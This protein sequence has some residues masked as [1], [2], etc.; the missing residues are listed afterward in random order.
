MSPELIVLL[1]IGAFVLLIL[2]EVP[3]GI[4]IG[5]AGVF[6]LVLL[7]GTRIGGRVLATTP[8]TASAKYALIVIPMYILLGT[9][10][11][12]AG[13]G[14]RIYR[15]VNRGVRRLP[16][17]LGAAAV[18]A[19]ALFSGISGSSAADVATFGRISVNEMTRHGYS[20]EYAAAVVAAAGTF[21]ALIPPSVTLVIYAIV[22]GENVGAM[23][24]AGVVPGALS[25]IIL[26]GMVVGRATIGPPSVGG[27]SSAALTNS[28][29]DSLE[30]A[31]SG[32]TAGSGTSTGG[33]ALAERKQ[34]NRA[35][36]VAVLYAAI[37]FGIVVGGLYGGVFTPTESGAVGALAAL[38][39]AL[40]A[41]RSSEMSV[42]QLLLRSLR[43][44]ASVTAMIFLL[45]IG[46]AIFSILIASSRIPADLT[47]WASSLPVPPLLI[48]AL[49]LVVLLVLGMFLDGLSTLLLTVPLMAPVV[50]GLGFEGVWFGVLVLKAIEI[51]LITPPVG[52]N[53]FIIAGISKVPVWDVFRR[54]FPFVVLDIA[55]TALLFAF[56]DIVLWMPRAA[57]LVP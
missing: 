46:G 10:I 53:A 29:S 55:V 30:A 14:T 17:G 32:T 13:I 44:T 27:R 43:E 16:G 18:I 47:E 4:S 23:I 51:G 6:G 54:L 50:T 26:V 20:R 37:I 5:L 39:I 22:S 34:Q 11:A 57:D 40:V 28:L 21:A 1:A 35:D 8:Y 45:L 15:A 33:V 31:A 52:I 49:F 12:N 25:A 41:R 24:I 38:V 3:V 9:L 42:G 56:P 2:L 36:A 48:V 7:N 19:T